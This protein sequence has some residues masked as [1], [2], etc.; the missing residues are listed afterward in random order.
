ME[1]TDQIEDGKAEITYI[2]YK[3]IGDEN[4]FKYQSQRKNKE[5]RE[6][7]SRH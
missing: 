7:R 6:E 5:I 4:Q 2:D 3:Q 1:Q